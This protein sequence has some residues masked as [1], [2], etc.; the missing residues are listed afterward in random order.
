MGNKFLIECPSCG[1]INEASTSFFAKRR[2]TCVC[3]H[4]IDVKKE[5]MI[6][7][8]CSKCG[9]LIVYNKAKDKEPVCPVCH[10]KLI[11]EK[12]DWKNVEIICPECSCQ[13]VQEATEG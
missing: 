9:N 7:R 5:K 4:V 11:N 10:E 3:G 6:T 1:R 13:H 8:K 2:I 12:D